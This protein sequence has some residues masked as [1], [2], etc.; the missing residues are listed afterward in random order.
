MSLSLNGGNDRLQGLGCNSTSLIMR[1]EEGH[2]YGADDSK[3]KSQEGCGLTADEQLNDMSGQDESSSY[4]QVRADTR[5]DFQKAND[6]VE[7]ASTVAADEEA[8]AEL[9]KYHH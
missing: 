5:S 8:A 7:Q 6:V 9:E 3:M 2:S 1:S 4:P